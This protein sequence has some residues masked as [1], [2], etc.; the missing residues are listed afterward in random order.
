MVDD[1]VKNTQEIGDWGSD[2]RT[3][4]EPSMLHDYQGSLQEL[5]IAV[6]IGS[7]VDGAGVGLLLVDICPQT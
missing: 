5:G 7:C 1:R 4:K 2:A 3:S 6:K